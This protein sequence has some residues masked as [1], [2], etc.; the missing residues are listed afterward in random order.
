VQA[1]RLI[2]EALAATNARADAR[3]CESDALHRELAELRALAAA[4]AAAD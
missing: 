3:R 2:A 1:G 4:V